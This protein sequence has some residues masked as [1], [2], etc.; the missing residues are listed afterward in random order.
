M[1]VQVVGDVV[2]HLQA[3]QPSVVDGGFDAGGELVGLPGAVQGPDMPRLPAKE[4]A[5]PRCSCRSKVW[6]KFPKVSNNKG[7]DTSPAAPRS[8]KTHP[9]RPGL[10]SLDL[11]LPFKPAKAHAEEFAPVVHPAWVRTSVHSSA[12]SLSEVS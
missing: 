9:A 8:V 5:P 12:P 6:S 7:K 1:R 11:G 4:T 3:T 10:K 2:K